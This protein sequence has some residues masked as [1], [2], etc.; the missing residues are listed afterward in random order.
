MIIPNS[1]NPTKSLYYL[2]SK[3]LEMLRE[4]RTNEFSVDLIYWKFKQKEDIS[5]KKFNLILYWLFIANII[6]SVVD[7]KGYIKL[8]N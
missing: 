1:I 4:E 7:K 6:E 8:C 2:G 3:L 5:F